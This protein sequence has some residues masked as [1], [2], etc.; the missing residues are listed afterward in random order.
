MRKI[1]VLQNGGG[2][3]TNIGNAFI[4]LGSMACLS[5]AA[6]KANM[7]AE[8]HLASVLG[9]WM[10]YHVSRGIKGYLL[11]RPGETKNA[12]SLQDHAR[13]DYV[14][15]WGAFLSEHWLQLQAGQQMQY[16][17][18]DMRTKHSLPQQQNRAM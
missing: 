9:R 7:Q 18:D 1:T 14:V 3:A 12:F 8:V 15:Q 2:W 11:R 17:Q 16:S 13:I 4:D 10:F 6:S 5:E